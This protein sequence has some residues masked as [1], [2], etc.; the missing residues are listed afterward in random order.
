[1]NCG[2]GDLA[3]VFKSKAGNYG[4]VVTCLRLAPAE[5][6]GLNLKVGLIWL[7]DQ[8]VFCIGTDGSLVKIPYM[9]DENLRPLRGDLTNDDV[10]TQINREAETC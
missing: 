1:M 7:I 3:Y 4:R 6:H 8:L 10:D 5:E 9:R 2:Q